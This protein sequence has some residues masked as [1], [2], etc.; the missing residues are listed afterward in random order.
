M[1][2]HFIPLAKAS[3]ILGVPLMAM[4]Q[5]VFD[6]KLK[7]YG[8]GPEGF[9]FLAEDIALLKIREPKYLEGLK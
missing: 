8:N 2:G 9:H 7:P 3:E 1:K 4:G 6:G 5:I